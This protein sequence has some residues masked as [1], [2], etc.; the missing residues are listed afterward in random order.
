MVQQLRAGRRVQV[1]QLLHWYLRLDVHDAQNKG[2]VLD[3]RDK[4]GELTGCFYDS[5][6]T[7][8]DSSWTDPMTVKRHSLLNV[9]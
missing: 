2:C 6:V 5:F 8:N 9:F 3:L 4:R 1:L 7:V